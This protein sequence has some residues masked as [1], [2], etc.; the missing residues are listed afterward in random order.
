MHEHGVSGRPVRDRRASQRRPAA[1]RRGS[2]P[3]PARPMANAVAVRPT[4]AERPRMQ[5]SGPGGR[6]PLRAPA[7][8]MLV[9]RPLA[10]PPAVGALGPVRRILAG[11]AVTVVSAA[12]MVGL[13]LLA[14]R[15]AASRGAEAR[16]PVSA[17]RIVTDGS[18]SPV[19]QHPGQ[20]LRVTSD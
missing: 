1:R 3:Q 17:E 19:S 5:R 8:R 13:G 9:R 18:L 7:A 12:L 15:V 16:P 2:G 11:L 10:A 4:E 14:D 20:V 6:A